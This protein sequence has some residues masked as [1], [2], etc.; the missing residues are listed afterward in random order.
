MLH[1]APVAL[2]AACLFGGWFIGHFT[3]PVVMRAREAL[4]DAFEPDVSPATLE[5]G[6]ALTQEEFIEV[7]KRLNPWGLGGSL[8][9]CETERILTRAELDAM[10][11]GKPSPPFAIDEGGIRELVDRHLARRARRDRAERTLAVEQG[12]ASQAPDGWECGGVSWVHPDRKGVV[13]QRCMTKHGWFIEV[14]RG[15]TWRILPSDREPR[16][17]LSALEAMESVEGGAVVREVSA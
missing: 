1:E 8:V 10:S 4:L 2:G 12:D 14:G 3:R 16:I 15:G 7:T 6:G 17:Y 9:P 11:D 13:V 5:T